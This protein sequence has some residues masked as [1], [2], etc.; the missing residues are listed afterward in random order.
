[1]SQATRTERELFAEQ[2]AEL[3][4][5]ARTQTQ[6]AARLASGIINGVLSCEVVVVP[7][8]GV[9][10]REWGA[11]FGSVA[12]SHHG[13]GVTAVMVAAGGPVGEVAPAGGPTMGRLNAGGSS[14]FALTGHQLTVW[15]TP[16][17]RLTL[18]VFTGCVPPAF[19]RG[20]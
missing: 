8:E 5:L 16:G 11:A 10:T 17:D 3:V 19:A 4:Y 7:A 18:Q 20:T 2:L 15:A 6:Q 1:M 9:V 12:I 13:P 14:T